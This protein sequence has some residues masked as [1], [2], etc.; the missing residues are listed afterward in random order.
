MPAMHIQSET[1]EYLNEHVPATRIH[2]TTKEDMLK[3]DAT[4]RKHLELEE[5]RDTHQIRAVMPFMKPDHTIF[6]T[7]QRSEDQQTSMP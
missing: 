2:T 6:G 3:N 5:R 7:P 1:Q 4:L